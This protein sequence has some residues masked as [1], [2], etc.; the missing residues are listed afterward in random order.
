MELKKKKEERK[1][2]RFSPFR[3][4][5]QIRCRHAPFLP[6][7]ARCLCCAFV[8][9]PGWLGSFSGDATHIVAL[10]RPGGALGDS[11]YTGLWQSFG[12]AS[13]SL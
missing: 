5:P 6:S 1:K 9:H 12:G 10:E 2:K 13:F 4:P 7:A 3:I 8:Q 11:A